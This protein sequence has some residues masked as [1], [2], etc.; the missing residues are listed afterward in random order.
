MGRPKIYSNEEAL[1]R[2]REA[3][4]VWR[5]SHRKHLN[6]YLKEWRGSHKSQ[7]KNYNRIYYLKG[8]Y[9]DTKRGR[10][11]I[12]KPLTSDEIRELEP[13]ILQDCNIM[14]QVEV[15]RKYKISRRTVQRVVAKYNPH[16]KGYE[17]K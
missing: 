10:L 1:Q 6:G 17:G 7:V 9:L 8:K 16:S 13:L 3:S 12:D 15:A 11:L 4:S 2:Q 5:K 14:T